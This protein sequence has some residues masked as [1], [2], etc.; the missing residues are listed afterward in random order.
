VGAISDVWAATATPDS[1]AVALDAH[2]RA[3]TT[4]VM[5]AA[6]RAAFVIALSSSSRQEAENAGQNQ[7]GAKTG[8]ECAYR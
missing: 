8:V 6:R 1:A 7:K 4:T 2:P 5:P 3:A